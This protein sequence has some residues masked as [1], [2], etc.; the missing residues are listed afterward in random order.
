M[1]MTEEQKYQIRV[2]RNQ[3]Q[4]YKKIAAN[5]CLSRDV[6]RGYCKR[7]GINGFGADLAEQHNLNLINEKT[8]VYCLQCDSKLVQSK[9][10]KKK[11]YCSIDCKRDWEKNNRKVYKLWCQYC[12]KQYISQSN[13][14]KFCS[15][16]CYVR[17]RFFKEEDG[18]EILGKI[19]K[20]K[21]VEFIPKWLEELLLSYLKDY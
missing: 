18:A 4:G 8:Y 9:R 15:N 2:M 16:D 5:L 19:L 20:R 7:N 14:S 21:S 10:G 6:V 17:N 13:N 3:G 1:I 11:K 12:R